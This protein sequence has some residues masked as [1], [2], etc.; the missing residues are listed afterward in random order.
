MG[1]V[2]EV[3]HKKHYVLMKLKCFTCNQIMYFA[4]TEKEYKK[5]GGKDGTPIHKKR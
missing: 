2:Q 3:K 4:V 1:V 5:L